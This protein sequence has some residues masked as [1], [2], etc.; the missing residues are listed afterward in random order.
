M[1]NLTLAGHAR[2]HDRHAAGAS[3]LATIRRPRA[4]WSIWAGCAALWMVLHFVNHP[5]MLDLAVYRSE[6]DAL[7]HG[8]ALYGNIGAPFDLKGTYPPF[9]TMLFVPLTAVPLTVCYLAA[10]LANLAL[11]VA[12]VALT[13][14]LLGPERLPAESVPLI[15]AAL[16]WVEPVYLTL[17]YGQINL[18]LLVLVLWDLTAPVGARRGGIGIGLAAAIKVTPGLLIVYLLLTRR[19]RAAAT[20]VGTALAATLVSAAVRPAETWRFWTDLVFRTDRVGNVASPENQSLR[21][22][23]ARAL[24]RM[25]PGTLGLLLTAVVVVAGLA[26]GV[27]AYRSLGEPAGVC[28]AS[29]TGLLVSPVSWSHHWVWCVPIA[30]ALVAAVRS[31][32]RGARIATAGYLVTFASYT[33]WFFKSDPQA[34]LHMSAIDQARSAPFVVFGLVFL[35]ASAAVAARRRATAAT[36][37]PVSRAERQ[38]GPSRGSLGRT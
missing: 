12:A 37:G 24:G 1:A 20:A 15:S 36:V 25:D 19:W 11:I 14:R 33:F 16:I 32:T 29:I 8:L 10:G 3:L 9:A 31:G 22:V 21:G 6:G 38:Y 13:R 17:H 27:V 7:R 5:A 28:A 26:A 4:A 35:G 18:A 23:L 30:V 2:R 34:N